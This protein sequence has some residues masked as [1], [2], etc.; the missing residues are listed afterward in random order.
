MTDNSTAKSAWPYIVAALIG[1]VPMILT[2]VWAWQSISD[3]EAQTIRFTMGDTHKFTLPN[4][5]TYSVYHEYRSIYEG[6]VYDT[7]GKLVNITFNVCPAD[8]EKSLALVVSAWTMGYGEG[9]GYSNRAG[10]LLFDF[11]APAGGD[12]EISIASQG[13]KPPPTFVMTVKPEGH[14]SGLVA[15]VLGSACV[16]GVCV[17]A[18]VVIIIV[19]FFKR[20]KAKRAMMITHP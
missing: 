18:A 19:T 15:V 6:T 20:R 4:A 17:L 11:D 16:N 1:I 13:S 5:G 10:T 14:V 12:Y 9:E 2:G 7:E 8:S 3:M